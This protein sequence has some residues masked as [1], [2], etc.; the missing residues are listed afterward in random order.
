MEAVYFPANFFLFLFD[1]QTQTKNTK[2][3]FFCF[4]NVVFKNNIFN[5]SYRVVIF[6]TFSFLSLVIFIESHEDLE[7]KVLI[8]LISNLQIFYII[9]LVELY[10]SISFLLAIVDSYQEIIQVYAYE[11]KVAEGEK[12][13]KPLN[14]AKLGFLRNSALLVIYKIF[15]YK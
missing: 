1:Y 13:K 2:I 7:T 8:S 4:R 14:E 11:G 5:I 10:L 9:L 12:K 15:I 6:L 3:C